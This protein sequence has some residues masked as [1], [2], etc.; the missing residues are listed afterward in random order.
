MTIPIP[1]THRYPIVCTALFETR[2]FGFFSPDKDDK[3]ATN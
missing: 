2:G 1:W 3:L